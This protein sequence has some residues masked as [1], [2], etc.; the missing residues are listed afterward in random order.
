MATRADNKDGSCR[1]IQTGRH[2]GKWRVQF[3][4]KDEFG[5]TQRLSRLFPNKTEGKSFLGDLR[6]GARIE[7]AQSKK[8][9]TL[10]GWFDWLVEHDWPEELDEKTIAIRVGRFN[11]YVRDV[12][13]PLPLTKIDPLTV[14]SYY[15]RLRDEGVGESTVHGIKA[16]LVRVFNQA[17][18][19]YQRV[20]MT[21]AN[22]FRLVLKSPPPRD[23]I[24]LTPAEAREALLSEDL[25]LEQRTMLAVFLLAGLRLSEQMALTKEQLLFDQDLIFVDRA[26][27]LKKDGAQY[28]GLPK[29]DKK[30]LAVMCPALKGLLLEMTSK[31]A[32]DQVLWPAAMENKPRQKKLVYATWRTIIKDAKLPKSMSPHDCRLTHINWIE[33]L[34]PQVSATT[35]KEHVGHAAEGV[36]EVNYTRPITPSQ[37]LLR[38]GIEMLISEK[39]FR[40]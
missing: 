7:A 15:R 23:A 25:T 3:S 13:G 9:L 12:L 40:G 22:P 1:E 30:R 17:V 33:K 29:G 16:N 31:M 32:G 18:T 37:S 4:F 26:V 28:L 24:A 2:K 5:R 34:L 14:R 27:K 6:R 19:P 39:A 21:H 36:T 10:S 20:P 8:E 11:K 38:E 35:L